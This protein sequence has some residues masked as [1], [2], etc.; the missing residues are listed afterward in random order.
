MNRTLVCLMAG[1]AVPTVAQ[2]VPQLE[3][4]LAYQQTWNSDFSSSSVL[5]M[6]SAQPGAATGFHEFAVKFQLNGAATGEDFRG[7]GFSLSSAGAGTTLATQPFGSGSTGWLPT[8]AEYDPPG[9]PAKYN[10]FETNADPSNDLLNIVVIQ[11]NAGK[12]NTLQS[13]EASAQAGGFPTELGLFYVQWDGVSSATLSVNPSTGPD[14]FS[15]FTNN[16]SGTGGNANVSNANVLGDSFV[17]VPEPATLG[18][19]GLGALMGLRRRRA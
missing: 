12:A 13:G 2:A 10:I 7:I 15:Y 14:I 9:P 17:L 4:V 8:T 18:L 16:G 6:S 1:L 11:S 5:D 3:L 19:L